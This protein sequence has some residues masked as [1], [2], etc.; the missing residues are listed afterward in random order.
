MIWGRLISSARHQARDESGASLIEYTV[1]ISLFLLVY[2]AVLDFGRLG[3]NWVMTEKAMQRAARIATVRPPVCPGVPATHQLATGSSDR[4]GTLCRTGTAC[5]NGGLQICALGAAADFAAGGGDDCTVA[6]GAGTAKEI[7]C[8]LEP[9]LP[10]NATPNNIFVEY[11]Y[12]QNLG[13]AGGPYSPMVTVGIVTATETSGGQNVGTPLR[14]EF[15]TPIPG[16]AAIA[17]GVATTNI[18][19]TTNLP[20]IPFPSINVSLPGEDL[21]NGT[22][23]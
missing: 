2:F 15:L 8:I 18:D 10:S 21:N 20:S 17:G 12:N 5:A 7:W 23:G 19:Q 4:F 3:F 14:F 9:I 6:A 1:V 13:F 16:L 11:R 22:N